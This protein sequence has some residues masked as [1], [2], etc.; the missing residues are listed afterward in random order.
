MVR[1]GHRLSKDIG[2]FVPDPQYL[3]YVNPNLRDAA[4][5]VSSGRPV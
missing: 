4:E 5:E 2:L 1:L 3:G